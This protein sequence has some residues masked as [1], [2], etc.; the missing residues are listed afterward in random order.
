MKCKT[1]FENT[2]TKEG[3]HL[4]F[5]HPNDLERYKRILK[6][7]RI[8]I[9]FWWYIYVCTYTHLKCTS[10]SALRRNKMLQPFFFFLKS[11]K[12]KSCFL[13]ISR[14]TKHEVALT[15]YFFPTHYPIVLKAENKKS[16][17]NSEG[18]FL[19]QFNVLK[20]IIIEEQII[21]ALV[22]C[23]L[24][25]SK[26]KKNEAQGYFNWQKEKKFCSK[27]MHT[28]HIIEY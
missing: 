21:E 9:C 20:K 17:S 16:S 25:F 19:W 18:C 4:R 24:G 5:L 7:Q 12:G 11:T 22:C 1:S 13:K 23:W 15:H 2:W 8:Q 6:T 10:F 28:L 26:E 3:Y 27:E 14:K